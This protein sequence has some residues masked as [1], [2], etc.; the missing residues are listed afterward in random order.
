ME[1]RKPDRVESPL[2]GGVYQS[3]G[4]R[5]GFCFARILGFL[6]LVEQTKFHCSSHRSFFEPML[7]EAETNGNA[8]SGNLTFVI[9]SQADVGPI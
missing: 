9:G 2:L 4:L 7:T 8:R 5:E 3:E 6:K 1:L